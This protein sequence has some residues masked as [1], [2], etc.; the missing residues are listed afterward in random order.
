MTTPGATATPR[1]G[2]TGFGDPAQVDAAHRTVRGDASIQFDLPW[3][4]PQN[5]AP[6]RWLR[7]VIEAIERF[8]Q[9]VGPTGWQILGWVALAALLLTLAILLFPPLRRWIANRLVRRTDEVDL[10]VAWAPAPDVARALLEDADRLAAAGE[11]DRAVRLILHRSIADI[12]RWHGDPLRPSLTSRDL[13]GNGFTSA[14]FVSLP[15][16]ARAVFVRIVGDV[17]RSLFAGS[18][19]DASDWARARADYAGFA[20]GPR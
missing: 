14:R 1:D 10:P 2:A 17:E 9:W 18:P 5:T 20:L 16:A 6:P 19:L 7:E 11:Y 3:A 13:A 4:Q 12:E 15:D 8:S